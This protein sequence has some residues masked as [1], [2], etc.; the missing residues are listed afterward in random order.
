[1]THVRNYL[2]G[3]HRLL[4]PRQHVEVVGG[5]I[6]DNRIVQSTDEDMDSSIGIV[7]AGASS[8]DAIGNP[9]TGIRLIVRNTWATAG[10]L[11]IPIRVID[12]VLWIERISVTRHFE[13]ALGDRSHRRTG[14]RD[15]GVDQSINSIGRDSIANSCPAGGVTGNTKA[16]F[17]QARAQMQRRVIVVINPF[18]YGSWSRGQCLLSVLDTNRRVEPGVDPSDLD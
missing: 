7:I 14:G 15:R 11:T 12:Q 2:Q 6:Q 13:A 3:P 18:N 17:S 10:A 1:M 4:V 16:A 8:F 9:R 5:V